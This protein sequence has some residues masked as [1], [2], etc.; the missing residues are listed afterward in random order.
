MGQQRDLPVQPGEKP[1][2]AAGTPL[3]RGVPL[4]PLLVR[5]TGPVSARPDRRRPVH[6]SKADLPAE[7]QREGTLQPFSR[8]GV[9]AG[10][11][12]RQS[13]GFRFIALETRFDTEQH[14][15]I[16]E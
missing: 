1:A 10:P 15:E 12:A 13:G 4:K 5:H 16:Y 11:G 3:R 14:P 9:P 7:D 8:R 6:L 2:V